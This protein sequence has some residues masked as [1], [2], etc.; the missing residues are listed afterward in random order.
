MGRTHSGRWTEALAH[1]QTADPRL[2]P[3]I[4]SVGPCQ[5]RPTRDRFGT[6]VRAIVGQQ[7][8][9]K[10]AAAI[11]VRLKAEAGDPVEPEPLLRLGLAGLRQVGLSG[12]KAGYVIGL[13]EAVRDGTL[14][15]RRIGTWSDETIVDRLTAL[16]GIGRWTAEMFLIFGLNRADV[17]P[18]HDLGI[19]VAIRNHFTL[20]AIPTPRECAPLAE[21]WKPYRSIAAWYLWRSLDTPAPP[22]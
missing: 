12:R 21:P 13:A 7:I 11:T 20:A 2:T 6:L 8:S 17:L 1:L 16:K 5:L 22:A 14:P 19:R 18:I 15:L 3:V 9:T 10:A 4:R